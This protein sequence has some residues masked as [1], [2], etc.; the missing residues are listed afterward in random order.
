MDTI[1]GSD[2]YSNLVRPAWA[3]EL[4]Q[5]VS[6]AAAVIAVSESLARD[7]VAM[8]GADPR[9]VLV[10]PDT[11]DET[12]F[13]YVA[14]MPHAGPLRLVSV[15]RL[16]DVK[17]HDILLQAFARV[18]AEGLDAT[19][20]IVGGGPERQ[21]LMRL[22]A[23]LGVDD[24]VRMRGALGEDEL[25]SALAEADAFVMASRKEGFGVALVEA[26]ATGLPAIATRSGGP[27]AIL[28]DASGLLVS[29]EDPDDLSRAL[30]ELASRIDSYDRAS[31]AARV[32]SRYGA[33]VIGQRL[34]DLYRAVISDEVEA[35][36]AGGARHA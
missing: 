10:I 20:E 31:I 15:G 34:V 36:V 6:V 28:D 32:R 4:R 27:E 3:E 1:H 22:A 25:V 16:V 14:R 18:V 11:Y 8:I 30:R 23:D 24:R 33:E 5:T 21:S 2:L 7:A 35:H 19:L 9:R 29:P 17:G 13:H 26:L 12:R